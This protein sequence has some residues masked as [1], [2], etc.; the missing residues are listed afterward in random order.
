MREDLKA[1]T[2]GALRSAR[3]HVVN[4]LPLVI[5]ADLA[6][7]EVIA[8]ALGELLAQTEVLAP[9]WRTPSCPEGLTRR[10]SPHDGARRWH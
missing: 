4:G 7:D 6:L 9:G 1:T 10:P 2:H 8:R 3:S 5:F